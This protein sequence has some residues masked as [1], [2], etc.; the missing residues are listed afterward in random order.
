MIAEA[1]R[2]DLPIRKKIAQR[3][4]VRKS[5]VSLIESFIGKAFF[6][7]PSCRRRWPRSV[8]RVRLEYSQFWADPWTGVHFL[9]DGLN[10][11]VRVPAGGLV[12][13]D[14]IGSHAAACEVLHPS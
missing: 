11:F 10:F 13:K 2:D 5:I 9:K 12:L 6:I 14:Q 4:P 3:V 7:M 8:F 1:R